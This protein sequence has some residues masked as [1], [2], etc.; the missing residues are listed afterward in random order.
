M[1]QHDADM[2]VVAI[3]SDSGWREGGKSLPVVAGI[4]RVDESDRDRNLLR[5]PADQGVRRRSRRAAGTMSR[6]DRCNRQEPDRAGC[7][8]PHKL[9]LAPARANQGAYRCCKGGSRGN[10]GFPVSERAPARTAVCS[11]AAD[12]AAAGGA[13]LRDRAARCPPSLGSPSGLSVTLPHR[14]L[15]LPPTASPSGCA[16]NF[17]RAGGHGFLQ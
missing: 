8:T 5:L 3:A 13:P 11:R 17:V 7:N 16:A 1:E 12:P 10:H 9:R 6:G 2:P 4:E 15:V 14:R